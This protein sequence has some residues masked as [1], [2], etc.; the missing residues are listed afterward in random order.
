MARD[1]SGGLSIDCAC[2]AG[3]N[4]GGAAG[5]IIQFD[6]AGGNATCG[7]ICEAPNMSC[8][9]C[10]FWFSQPATGSVH[11]KWVKRKDVVAQPKP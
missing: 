10:R 6:D 5:C 9:S 3:C 4:P 2:G 8:G 1:N 11:A 7:G